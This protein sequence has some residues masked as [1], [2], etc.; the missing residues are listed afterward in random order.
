MSPTNHSHVRSVWPRADCGSGS[1]RDSIALSEV[2][3]I[4][5][6]GSPLACVG[7]GTI[8]FLST[9]EEFPVLRVTM[10]S[11]LRVYEEV[12]DVRS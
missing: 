8:T 4:R 6:G 7:R 3:A 9:H 11:A 2:E 1:A 10:N 5:Y 12:Q